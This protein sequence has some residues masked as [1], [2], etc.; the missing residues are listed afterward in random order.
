MLLCYNGCM[1]SF[2]DFR[3]LRDNYRELDLSVP[4]DGSHVL[5]VFV[6]VEELV[7]SQ[8]E[9]LNVLGDILQAS[10]LGLVSLFGDEK[11]RGGLLEWSRGRFRKISKRARGKRFADVAGVADKVVSWNGQ[12][13]AVF[14]PL[15]VDEQPAVLRKLQVSGLQV[16]GGSSETFTGPSL[17]VSVDSGL[18]MSPGKLVAQVGHAVQLFLILGDVRDVSSWLSNGVR[19]NV[20]LVGA[21]DFGSLVVV[22]DA[23]FTEIPEGSYTCTANF[24]G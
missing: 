1:F 9:R 24:V 15:F 6:V 17:L 22:Q 4:E 3:W 7:G 8:G 21:L 23:G 20:E 16:S 2:D 19:V 13:V 5:A 10:V 18:H 11:Y 14:A 12:R